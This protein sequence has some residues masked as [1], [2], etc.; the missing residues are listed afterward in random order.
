MVFLPLARH[1]GLKAV[2]PESE[3]L[4]YK[5]PMDH[6]SPCTLRDTGHAAGVGLN[7]GLVAP[8]GHAWWRDLRE[9]FA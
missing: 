7:L 2:L 5:L 3:L 6:E 1:E 4:S 9:D 8:V